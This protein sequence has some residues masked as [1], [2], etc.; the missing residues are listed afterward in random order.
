MTSS[1]KSLTVSL[2]WNPPC[3]SWWHV[4]M[5][6]C[7]VGSHRTLQW[8]MGSH[9]EYRQ[10]SNIS[11][12]KSQNV[13]VSCVVLQLSL[14]SPLKPGAKSRMKMLLEHRRQAMLQLHLIDQ[15]FIA[16][17]GA[18]YIRGLTEKIGGVIT[19]PRC[20]SCHEMHNIYGRVIV[21]VTAD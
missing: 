15:Q 13:N 10:T 1:W 12:T 11:R 8:Y 21:M 16:Y 9:C 5:V 4:E 14:P 17:W 2:W 7:T 6:C 20:T 19:G 18:D 3:W